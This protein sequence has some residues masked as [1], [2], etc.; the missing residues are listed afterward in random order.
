MRAN[1]YES[2]RYLNEYLLFHYGS[3]NLLCPFS[4]VSRQLLRFHE[5]IREECLLP[6]CQQGRTGGAAPPTCG[7]PTMGLDIGCA[8]GRFTFELGRVV[9]GVFGIDNSRQFIRAAQSM[10]RGQTLTVDVPESGAQVSSHQVV[11]PKPLRK[12]AV[13]FGVGDALNLRALPDHS[14]HVV[15][16]INLIDRL[17]R[18]R[19]FLEHLPRLLARGGQLIIASPFT[20]LSAHT[21]PR[22]WLTSG[23]MIELLAPHFKLARRADLPFVIREH[24]RKYQLVVSEVFVFRE[25]STRR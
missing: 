20:W 1:P 4:F 9:Y 8:V 10:A 22:Q 23:Q 16:A 18:P 11:L 3:P 12:C 19:Q 24:R 7:A 5:R 15:S 6:I 2:K 25:R 13:E 17:P 14:F 21:Q